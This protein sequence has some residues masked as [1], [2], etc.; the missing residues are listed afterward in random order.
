MSRKINFV[1]MSLLSHNT[2]F[3]VSV[4]GFIIAEIKINDEIPFITVEWF[5]RSGSLGL[6][7]MIKLLSSCWRN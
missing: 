1:S 2:L 5:L 3:L 7:G 4:I 6:K